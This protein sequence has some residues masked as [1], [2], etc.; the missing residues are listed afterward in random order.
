MSRCRL[1]SLAALF[2]FAQSGTRAAAAPLHGKAARHD[3][4]LISAGPW[5]S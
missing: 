3:R 2:L 1:D 5:F 4:R